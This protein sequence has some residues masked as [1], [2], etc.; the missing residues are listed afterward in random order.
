MEQITPFVTKEVSKEMSPTTLRKV[1]L[2]KVSTRFLRFHHRCCHRNIGFCCRVRRRIR[3]E[4]HARRPRRFLWDTRFRR[5]GRIRRRHRSNRPW[6]TGPG[7]FLQSGCHAK[8]SSDLQRG[9][10][11]LAH[12]LSTCCPTDPRI[13]GRRFRQLPKSWRVLTRRGCC[14]KDRWPGCSSGVKTMEVSP[15]ADCRLVS[16]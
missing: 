10:G 16:L 8:R 4:K 11:F 7:R 15:S 1:L 12:S 9:S 6:N 5:I 14:L 2:A 13:S 3:F